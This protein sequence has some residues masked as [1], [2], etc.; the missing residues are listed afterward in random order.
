[1]TDRQTQIKEAYDNLLA[2]TAEWKEG[3]TDARVL[4][5]AEDVYRLLIQS[6]PEEGGAR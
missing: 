6:P 4:S 3:R 2:V 5:D 1:M